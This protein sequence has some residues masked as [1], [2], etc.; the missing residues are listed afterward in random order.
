MFGVLRQGKLFI[1][2][3]QFDGFIATSIL[4]SD[5][6]IGWQFGESPNFSGD[7]QWPLTWTASFESSGGSRLVSWQYVK[8]RGTA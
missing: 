4:D 7:S 3:S 1:L 5:R 6:L 8:R 2:S